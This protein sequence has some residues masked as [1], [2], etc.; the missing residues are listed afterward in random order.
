LRSTDGSHSLKIGTPLEANPAQPAEV[1][2]VTVRPHGARN[3]GDWITTRAGK[4]DFVATYDSIG[5]EPDKQW[6]AIDT[7]PAS[8][9]YNRIYA[10]WV[11]F[12][13]RTPVP[14]VSYADANADGTHTTWS[15][16]APLPVAP[17]SPQG[18]TY[19]LPH[20]APDGT[21]YTTLTNSDPKKHYCCD[22]IT[23]DRSTDGGATWAIAGTPVPAVTPP[24]LIYPNTTFRDGIE[25]TFAVGNHAN[26]EGRYPLY[27]LYENNG[28][29]IDNV[30]LTASYD[31]GATWTSPIQ[32]NDNTTPVD[33][34]QPNL[35]C[36][37]RRQGQRR[38][39]RP[40][41]LLPGSRNCR[42]DRRRNRTRPGQPEL[43]RFAPALR[44]D[45][46]LRQREHRVL[47]P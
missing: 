22:T 43:P 21:V 8:P 34:F 47:H 44:R 37:R 18:V 15:R 13:N 41:D 20:V 31:G 32:V 23:V 19:L 1:I 27:V 33:E 17:N 42:G 3:A 14:Y 4:P 11:D 36:R 35:K 39:L 24:G 29:G 26:S 10:M 30:M 38:L 12:Y 7:N 9:H 5:N 2:G 16:P 28:A 46:L 40:P 25:D 6:L 45:Q